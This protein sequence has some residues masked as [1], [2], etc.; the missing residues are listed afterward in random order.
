M[1]MYMLL[2]ISSNFEGK[3]KKIYRKVLYIC[4]KDLSNDI[5]NTK[6]KLKQ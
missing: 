6:M 2:K 3:T 1:C 4:K 5:E